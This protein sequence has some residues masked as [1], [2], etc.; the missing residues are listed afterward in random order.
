M[1]NTQNNINPR[2]ISARRFSK[3]HGIDY[4]FILREIKNGTLKA[5]LY[6]SRFKIDKKEGFKWLQTKKFEP[7]QEGV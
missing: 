6:G 7:K 1:S 2:T 3:I 5:E 4:G